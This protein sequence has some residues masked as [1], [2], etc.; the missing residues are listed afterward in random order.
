MKEKANEAQNVEIDPTI[1]ELEYRSWLRPAP[2]NAGETLPVPA[3]EDE[4]D[5]R[6]A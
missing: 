4:R 6:A 3:V 2:L 1:E 5:K